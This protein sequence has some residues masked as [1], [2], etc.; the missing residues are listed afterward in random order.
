LY[1]NPQISATI[2]VGSLGLFEFACRCVLDDFVL[3]IISRKL[4]RLLGFWT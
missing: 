4:A 2:V 3:E 1:E